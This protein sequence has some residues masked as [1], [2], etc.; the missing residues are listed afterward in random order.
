MLFNWIYKNFAEKA[1]TLKD[2]P[3]T[4][5]PDTL[6]QI[7]WPLLLQYR[8]FPLSEVKNVLGTPIGTKIF[9][10][11]VEVL[12]IV[13]LIRRVPLYMHALQQ[14]IKCLRR[15]FWYFSIQQSHLRVL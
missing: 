10:L 2:V 4:V 6:D 3:C 14:W 13:S 5:A 9:I 1:I 12:S 15:N 11:I 8:G 7:F